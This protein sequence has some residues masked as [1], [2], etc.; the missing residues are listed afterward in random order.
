M[1]DLMKMSFKERVN[2]LN[3]FDVDKELKNAED[4]ARD[5]SEYFYQPISQ[6]VRKKHKLMFGHVKQPKT[7]NEKF[8]WLMVYLSIFLDYDIYDRFIKESESL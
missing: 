5:K 1:K 3:S 4:F 8:N 6:M 2:Y 7:K